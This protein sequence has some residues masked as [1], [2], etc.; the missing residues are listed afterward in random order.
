MRL[1]YL[2]L[3]RP[4]LQFSSKELARSMQ[5]PTRWDPEQLKRAVRFLI[6]APRIVQKFEEQEMPKKV[7]SCSDTDH[8]GCLKTRK[9]T[10][11]SMMFLGKHMVKSSASTQG[12]I[13]L[14][15]GE[16]EFYGAVKTASSGLGMI[17]L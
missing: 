3:D 15:S 6:G 13:A 8:A 4:E 14:S 12:V 1:A 10:S 2:A 11:C 9:S 7:T 17:H 16:S 5:E